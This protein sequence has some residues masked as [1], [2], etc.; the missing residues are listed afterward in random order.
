MELRVDLTKDET[1][2]ALRICKDIIEN[3]RDDLNKLAGAKASIFDQVD[4]K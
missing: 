1:K 3:F 2:E 4:Q